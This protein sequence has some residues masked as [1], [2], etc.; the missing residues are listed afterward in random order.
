LEKNIKNNEPIVDEED[1]V[2]DIDEKEEVIIS[3]VK[4]E[5]ETKK[6][7]VFTEEKINELIKK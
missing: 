5:K 2:A 1:V 6:D 7:V 4:K 3:E